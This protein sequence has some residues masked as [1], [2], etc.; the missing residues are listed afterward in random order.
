MNYEL[1]TMKAAGGRD[2]EYVRI[3]EHNRQSTIVSAVGL[4]RFPPDI[5]EAIRAG[6]PI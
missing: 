4:W 2:V 6:R 5:R 3:T 1:R